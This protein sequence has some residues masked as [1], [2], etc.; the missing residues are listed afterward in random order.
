MLPTRRRLSGIVALLALLMT[1]CQVGQADQVDQ[2]SAQRNESM[3]PGIGHVHGLGIDPA[4]GSIYVAGH[5]GLFQ[6]RA[7]NTAVR[8]ADRVQDYMGFT[9][10]GPKTFLASGHPSAVDVAAGSPAHLGLIRTADAGLTW[11][12][13]SEA[14]TA[15]FHA[16]QPAGASLYAYDSQ[17][18]RIRR[19]IDNGVTW[20]DGA[21][22]Q[23]ADLAASAD[24]PD[25]LYA[26]TPEGPVVSQ[27]GG[28]TFTALTGAP[29]LAFLDAPGKGLLVGIATDRTVR[30]SEDG[31]KTWKTQGTVP[32]PAAAFSTTDG[33]R[34]LMATEEGTVYQSRD[35]GRTFSPAYKPAPA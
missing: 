27:D 18:G 24:Q 15:D 21:Q 34:L 35:G 23:V 6:V 12:T 5:F 10:V 32:G 13:V 1:G 28:K 7:M 11:K 22:L 3:D 9:V 8:I 33:R 30:R 19:S 17:S 26:T 25:R 14:G 16:L 20:A 31:G 2:T 4:D 29:L